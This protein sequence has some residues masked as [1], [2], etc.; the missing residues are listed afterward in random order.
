MRPSGEA[1]VKVD[2][3]TRRMYEQYKTGLPLSVVATMNGLSYN[4]LR[5]RFYCRGL[6]VRKRKP[7]PNFIMFEGSRFTKRSDGIYRRTTGKQDSLGRAVWKKHRGNIPE[8]FKICYIDGNRANHAIENL[9]CV[10]HG[11]VRR[12]YCQVE[13]SVIIPKSC[14]H[15]GETMWRRFG[16][17]YRENP[18]MYAKRRFCNRSCASKFASKRRKIK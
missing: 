15:C 5:G 3:E 6:A 12:R 14:K 17:N 10:D 11:D 18:A 8:G 9:D 1:A 4:S 2:Q 7:N 16:L 13:K